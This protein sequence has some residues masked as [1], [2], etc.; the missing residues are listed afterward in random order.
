MRCKVSIVAQ[1]INLNV[2]TV[3]HFDIYVLV[4]DVHGLTNTQHLRLSQ[5][6]E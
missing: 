1:E 6:A 3:T 4:K 5:V 2:L